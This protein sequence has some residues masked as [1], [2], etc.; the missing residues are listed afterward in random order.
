MAMQYG[1]MTAC[2]EL[3]ITLGSNA[4]ELVQKIK[5]ELVKEVDARVHWGLDLQ[6]DLNINNRAG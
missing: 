2:I 5:N 6:V 3:A 1:K 4:D